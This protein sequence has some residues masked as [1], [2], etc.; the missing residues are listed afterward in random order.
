[1][2]YKPDLWLFQ[3]FEHAL[4]IL[5]SGFIVDIENRCLRLLG[6]EIRPVALIACTVGIALMG[7]GVYRLQYLNL[8]IE[9]LLPL[10]LQIMTCGTIWVQVV[11]LNE[12]RLRYR[13]IRAAIPGNTSAA[14]SQSSTPA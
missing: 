10:V 11:M 14:T 9:Q 3:V 12:I 7:I 8:T 1:N 5:I 13:E 6:R 2:L 4:V